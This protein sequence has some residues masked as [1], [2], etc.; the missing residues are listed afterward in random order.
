[1]INYPKMLYMGK[2]HVVVQTPDE[3]KVMLEDG[4]YQVERYLDELKNPKPI[5]VEVKKEET[6]VTAKPKGRPKKV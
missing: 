2:E 6:V 1:M 4:W 5:V 3:E